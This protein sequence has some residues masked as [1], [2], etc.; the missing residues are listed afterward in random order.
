MHTRSKYGFRL[1]SQCLNL[2]AEVSLSSLPKTYKSALLDPNWAG[3]MKDEYSVLLKNNTCLLV[4]R[5]RKTNI[6]SGK[7]GFR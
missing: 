4:P 2:H 6:V 5:P 1:P 3:A 7:W